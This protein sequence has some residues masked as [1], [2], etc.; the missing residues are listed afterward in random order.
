M[1]RGVYRSYYKGYKDKIKE[2]GRGMVGRWEEIMGGKG[3]GLSGK[4]GKDTWTK[5]K[6]VRI[7]GG[8][9]G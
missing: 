6:E 2:E 7:E 4:R 3:K 1:G 9:W 5:P 8:R